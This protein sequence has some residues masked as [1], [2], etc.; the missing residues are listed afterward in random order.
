MESHNN[1]KCSTQLT[2]P[3]RLPYLQRATSAVFFS[4]TASP[5]I[6]RPLPNITA[7]QGPML[8]I[9]QSTGELLSQL[10]LQLDSDPVTELVSVLD[11][12]GN[13]QPLMPITPTGELY[14]LRLVSQGG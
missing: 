8:L 6:F 10:Q 2:F 14:L 13:T 12:T 1:N 4:G 9:G 11:L 7:L 3:L 5:Y